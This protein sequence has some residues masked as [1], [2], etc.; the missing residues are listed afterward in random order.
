MDPVLVIDLLYVPSP[1]NVTVP[2]L[3]NAL[4]PKLLGGVLKVPPAAIVVVPV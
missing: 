3:T 2:A 4:E 1:V